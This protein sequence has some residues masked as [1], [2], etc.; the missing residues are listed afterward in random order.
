MKIKII[1]VF[2]IQYKNMAINIE[3]N[4]ERKIKKRSTQKKTIVNSKP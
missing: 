3:H 1:R 4:Y 2:F